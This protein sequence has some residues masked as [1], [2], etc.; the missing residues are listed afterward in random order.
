M[1]SSAI[2]KIVD[3]NMNTD[4]NVPDTVYYGKNGVSWVLRFGGLCAFVGA[5]ISRRVP[6][7]KVEKEMRWRLAEMLELSRQGA[8]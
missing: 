5:A 2:F 4:P 7:T 3:K 6:P 8:A 1:I